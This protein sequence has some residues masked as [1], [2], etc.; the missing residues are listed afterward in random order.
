MKKV[1]RGIGIATIIEKKI[2][3]DYVKFILHSFIEII[4]IAGSLD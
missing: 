1:V 2:I 3:A 4:R